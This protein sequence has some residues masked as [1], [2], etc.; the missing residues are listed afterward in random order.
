M[1]EKLQDIQPDI[2]TVQLPPV[3]SVWVGGESYLL[4][5]CSTFC[6]EQLEA[7]LYGGCFSSSHKFAICYRPQFQGHHVVMLRDLAVGQTRIDMG[8]DGLQQL[9]SRRFDSNLPSLRKRGHSHGNGDWLNRKGLSREEQHLCALLIIR[10][11]SLSQYTRIM[12]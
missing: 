3:E 5:P 4:P 2:S 1:R 12:V 10:L 9:K 7:V 6:R 11:S 8:K